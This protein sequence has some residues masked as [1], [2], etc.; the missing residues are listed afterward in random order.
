MM[1][2]SY[3]FLQLCKRW[4]AHLEIPPLHELKDVARAFRNATRKLIIYGSTSQERSRESSPSVRATP[5]WTAAHTSSSG[6][7]YR[8]M[9]RDRER[10]RGR[11]V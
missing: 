6:A 9:F 2:Q 11:E 1:G 3:K 5:A 4:C 7:A 10:E 8:S